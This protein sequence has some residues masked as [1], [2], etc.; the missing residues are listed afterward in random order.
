[1]RNIAA[2]AVAVDAHEKWPGFEHRKLPENE[3]FGGRGVV[4]RPVAG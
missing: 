3:H 1:M 2:I 4:L